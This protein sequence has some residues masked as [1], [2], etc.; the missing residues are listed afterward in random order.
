MKKLII[1]LCLLLVGCTT[2]SETKEFEVEEK[3]LEGLSE[4]DKTK[5]IVI[6]KIEDDKAWIVQQNPDGTITRKVVDILDNKEGEQ[7][8]IRFNNPIYEKPEPVKP[9]QEDE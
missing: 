2:P 3:E 1:V 6:E 8:K 7:I 5:R 4:V 9:K